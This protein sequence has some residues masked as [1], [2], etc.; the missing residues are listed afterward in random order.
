MVFLPKSVVLRFLQDETTERRTDHFTLS[1]KDFW[2]N[3]RL[4]AADFFR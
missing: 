2:A 1:S 4:Q 3:C